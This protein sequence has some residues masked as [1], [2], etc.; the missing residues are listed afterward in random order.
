MQGFQMLKY[1]YSTEIL[2]TSAFFIIVIPYHSKIQT[3]PKFWRFCDSWPILI[4]SLILTRCKHDRPP[5]GITYT[6]GRRQISWTWLATVAISATRSRS[7]AHA[8]STTM[9]SQWKVTSFK[10]AGSILF[11][12]KKVYHA[13][14]VFVFFKIMDTYRHEKFCVPNKLISTEAVEGRFT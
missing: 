1:H 9:A 11:F 10:N 14:Y 4:C 5:M 13:L 7:N 8:L 3:Q 2:G 6:T 12:E